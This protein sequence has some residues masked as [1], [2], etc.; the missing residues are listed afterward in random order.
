MTS[1]EPNRR[2]FLQ[3]TL[4]AV[5]GLGVP[6]CS[7]QTGEQAAHANPD[8][9]TYQFTARIEKNAGVEPFQVGSTITGWFTYDLAAEDVFMDRRNPVSRHQSLRNML[10]FQHG[11][12]RFIGAGRISFDLAWYDIME[13]FGIVAHDLVLPPGWE[14]DRIGRSQS[15]GLVLQ[16]APPRGVILPNVI[17]DQ[18]DLASFVDYREFNLDFFHGVTFPGG[19]VSGRATVHAVMERLELAHEVG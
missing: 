18:L 10:V 14:I 9:R 12:N 2:E 3:T 5:L 8:L 6:A 17:P 16:N 4:A 19:Q 13:L 1:H 7:Q 15:F 11:K